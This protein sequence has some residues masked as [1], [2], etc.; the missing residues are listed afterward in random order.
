MLYFIVSTLGMISTLKSEKKIGRTLQ[1]FFIYLTILIP[2]L[3]WL[4]VKYKSRKLT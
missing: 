1:Y 2:I 3:G 4:I